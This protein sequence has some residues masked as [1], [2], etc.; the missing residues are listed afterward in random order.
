MKFDLDRIR[1]RLST[2]DAVPLLAVLG[3]LAGLSSGLIIILFRLLVESVLSLFLPEH[4]ENFEGLNPMLQGA[5]PLTCAI[6]L[7]A[8]FHYLSKDERRTGVTYVIER[9]NLYQGAISWRS[10]LVQFFGAAATLIGGLSMGREGPAVHLG[11]AG[12]SLLG[13]WARLPNNS[14]RI[15]TGCGCAAAISASFNTP[16]AGVIFAMEVIMM[17]Y[18]IS[19]FIPIILASVVGASLT[20]AVYGHEPAFNIPTVQMGTLLELPFVVIC[21]VII[22]CLAAA[23]IYLSLRFY[24]HTHRL[25]VGWRFFLAGLVTAACGYLAPEILGVGYDSVNAALVGSLTVTALLFIMSLKLLATS[26]CVGAGLPGGVIGPALFIGA[27]AGGLFGELGQALL[28]ED[29]NITLY[30]LLGMAGMMAATLEAPLAAL[31]ALLEL[32]FEPNIIFPGMLVVVISSLITTQ[33]FRQRGIF[34]G[35]LE[36]QGIA[37]N[38]S[39]LAQHLHRVGVAAVMDRNIRRVNQHLSREEA[40][41]ILK[42]QPN[43]L[44]IEKDGLPSHFMPAAELAMH[45]ANLDQAKPK[46]GAAPTDGASINLLEI[47][48]K[49]DNV[50]PVLLSATLHEALQAM[51]KADVSAVY[52]RRMS[53]PNIYRVFGVVRKQDIEHYY[54]I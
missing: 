42:K 20:R 43:W 23:L 1:E 49:R 25:G 2:L 53:A 21:G 9:F 3:I 17:E 13:Q 51:K 40:D 38:V 30:V 47:P 7:G 41:D 54:Q 33:V 16:I 48:A 28:P 24:Q 11:A 31:M 27:M 50:T 4:S 32:T 46:E 6:L 19:T 35:F 36:A 34:Q 15:L 39:P 44:L 29:A 45:L 12:G 37:L 8:A 18:S 26:A 5:L 22:G 10:L 14:V 52:V